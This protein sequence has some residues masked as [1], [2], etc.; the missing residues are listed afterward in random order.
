MS[1]Q[2]Y[3]LPLSS[4]D[5]YKYYVIFI[6]HF[7]KYTWLYP[8]KFKSDTKASFIKFKALVEKYFQ[9]PII[10]LYSDNEG[11]YDALNTYLSID[12]ISRLTSS[13]HT[14]Q[15]KWHFRMTS[16]TH[17]R[18]FSLLTH[19]SMSLTFWSNAR[20][21]TVYLINRLP[22]PTVKNASPYS[23]LFGTKPN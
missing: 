1:I 13:P 18:N 6:D 11:E 8:L 12:G 10:T 5:G 14:P 20:S 9:K 19:S 22:T 3:G 23:V 7:S 4:H 17:S 15:H 16:L 2:I 21:T